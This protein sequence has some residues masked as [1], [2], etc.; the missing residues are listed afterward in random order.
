MQNKY[1]F[2]VSPDIEDENESFI[3]KYYKKVPNIS[4]NTNY[5]LCYEVSDF[6]Q[7]KLETYKYVKNYDF[8]VFG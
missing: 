8:S 4:N 5:D 6:L 1:T 7:T 3:N 2:V